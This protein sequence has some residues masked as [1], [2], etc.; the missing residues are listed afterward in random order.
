MKFYCYYSVL[1]KHQCLDSYDTALIIYPFIYKLIPFYKSRC[2]KITT[3]DIQCILNEVTITFDNM[4]KKAFT[5]LS[6]GKEI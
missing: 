5:K 6:T 2:S 3:Q 1:L 4:T